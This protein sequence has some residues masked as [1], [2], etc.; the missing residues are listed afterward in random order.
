MEFKIKVST[1]E[2]QERKM[3]AIQEKKLKIEPK[4]SSKELH[5]KNA[6]KL[7][8]IQTMFDRVEKPILLRH[9]PTCT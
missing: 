7:R 6:E 2:V 9:L 1:F 5:A 3:D 8:Q 4:Y